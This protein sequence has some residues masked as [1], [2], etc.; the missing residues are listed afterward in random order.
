[1]SFQRIGFGVAA[2]CA[3]LAFPATA[4]AQIYSWRDASGTL[5]VSSQPKDPAAR[6]YA[7]RGSS[8]PVMTTRAPISRRAGAF[9]DLIVQHA[10]EQNISADLVRAVIQVES[11]F[12][13][14]ARSIK[15]AMGLMQLMPSTARELGVTNAYD[16][17]QNIRAG[18]HYLKQLLKRFDS[19]VELALAAYNAGPGAVE[20][21]GAVPPY[22]ETRNYVK[23]IRGSA[24]DAGTTG[25]SVTAPAPSNRVYRVVETIDGKESVRYSG[26]PTTGATLVTPYGR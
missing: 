10:N 5:V 11:A 8:A 16:P 15:G 21:Y 25:A 6:L 20:K 24:P 7:V 22:R 26:T 13:P 3:W 18:V 9:E 17:A 12:N 14:L 4:E 1:M 23:K 2:V 19:N